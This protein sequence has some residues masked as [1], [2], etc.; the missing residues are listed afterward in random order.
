MKTKLILCAVLVFGL[1]GCQQQA[2]VSSAQETKD[3]SYEQIQERIEEQKKERQE[4]LTEIKSMLSSNPRQAVASAISNMTNYSDLVTVLGEPDTIDRRV[5]GVDLAVWHIGDITVH[6]S[7]RKDGTTEV[8]AF[9]GQVSNNIARKT[10][11]RML[12]N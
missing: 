9:E 10:F 12:L 2:E 5:N 8:Y 6:V 7:E 3:E 11:N 1:V 4:T